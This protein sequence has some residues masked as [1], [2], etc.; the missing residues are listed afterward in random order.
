MSQINAKEYDVVSLES[1]NDA[2]DQANAI[3]KSTDTSIAENNS[4]RRLL[5]FDAL[6]IHI[7][8]EVIPQVI[9]DNDTLSLIQSWLEQLHR[10]AYIERHCAKGN[11]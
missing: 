7:R 2:C 5:E 10:P 4:Q 8:C 6:L 3:I 9:H 1:Y 11:I